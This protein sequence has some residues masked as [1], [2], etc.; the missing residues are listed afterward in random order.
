MTT[1]NTLT[2][3]QGQ[4][5]S[6]VDNVSRGSYGAVAAVAINAADEQMQ[7][8]ESLRIPVTPTDAAITPTAGQLP[9]DGGE[10]TVSNRTITLAN[11]R[12]V[13]IQFNAEEIKGLEKAGP[14]FDGIFQDR[15]SQAYEVIVDEMSQDICDLYDEASVGLEPAGTNLFDS[16]GHI[17]DSANAKRELRTN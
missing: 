5:Y 4:V 6:S 11:D 13:Q 7:K 8:G 12:A 14:G 1:P 10:V 3:L 16:T 9:N 17:Q 2:N 15:L